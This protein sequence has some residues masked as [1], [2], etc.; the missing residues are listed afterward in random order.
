MA[1]VVEKCLKL[2][3]NRIILKYSGLTVFFALWEVA[4]RFGWVDSQFVPSLFTVIDALK[5]L[6]I[7]GLLFTHAMVSL[8]RAFLGLGFAITAA[9]PI[10]ILLGY[11]FKQQ[12]KLLNPLFRLLSQVNPFSLS[13]V[14]IL[15][16]GIGEKA[17]VGVVAWVCLWPVLY[18]TINGIKTIDPAQ[19]KTALSMKVGKFGLVTKILLHGAA[20]SIFT[21]IRI[22]TQM[23]FFMLVAAEMIG[24]T[25]GLG[26]LLH[27]SAQNFQVPRIY[28]SGA[29][30]V[31]LGL[32]LNQC[33]KA[34]QERMFFWK[35]NRNPYFPEVE[36]KHVKPLGRSQLAV[37]AIAVIF[38]FTV[39]TWQI[40]ISSQEDVLTDH[41]HHKKDQLIIPAGSEF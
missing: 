26:W 20:P 31:I 25:S 40:Y 8:W 16:F 6:F 3:M 36:T 41:K 4:P 38:V 14:F 5:P 17:R 13:P 21:G 23:A 32:I 22:D 35:E 15:F 10:G 19:I 30:I 24:A 33:L 28:G 29:C 37:I 9:L 12:T 18:N 7:H 39:G 2:N 1:V 27:N 11:W 34:V